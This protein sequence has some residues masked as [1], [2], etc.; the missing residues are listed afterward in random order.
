MIVSYNGKNY[1]GY[2]VQN[3]GNTIQAELE[4]AIAMQ[5]GKYV[6]FCVTAD[7]ENAKT[8]IDKAF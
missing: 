6:V 5:K 3:N 2:Q 7:V 4:K 8:I 1:C